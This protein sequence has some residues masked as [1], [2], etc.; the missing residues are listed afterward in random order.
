MSTEDITQCKREDQ[1]TCFQYIQAVSPKTYLSAVSNPLKTLKEAAHYKNH[2]HT[3]LNADGS[4]NEVEVSAGGYIFISLSDNQEN[5][6]KNSVLSRHGMLCR[7]V[8]I[9]FKC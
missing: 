2:V 5:E 4:F 3:H 6:A 9:L 8:F 7:L 1:S